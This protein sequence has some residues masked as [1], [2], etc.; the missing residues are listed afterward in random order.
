MVKGS[1]GM[2]YER[3]SALRIAGPF[4]KGGHRSPYTGGVKMAI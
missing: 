3:H 4:M 2:G 1:F